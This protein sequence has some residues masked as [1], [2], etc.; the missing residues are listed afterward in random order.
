[1]YLFMNLERVINMKKVLILTIIIFALFCAGG[2]GTYTIL[3]NAKKYNEKQ[4]L[5]KV[6]TERSNEKVQE[7]QEIPVLNEAQL[8][9]QEQI[10]RIREIKYDL[11]L[12]EDSNQDFVMDVMHKMTHQKVRA[13]EK[14]GALPMSDDTIN[15][16]HQVVYNSNF[17][18]K[19]DLLEIL[20]EWKMGNYSRIVD[21]HNYFWTYKGGTIGK[22][23]GQLGLAEEEEFILQNF[24]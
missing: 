5:Q 10:N 8:L 18:L 20:A 22:A 4:E 19:D 17:V 11:N 14:E 16:V 23:Y 3:H 1:M 7:T 24:H 2:A 12:K 13:E 21:D 15:Q 6:S 9:E